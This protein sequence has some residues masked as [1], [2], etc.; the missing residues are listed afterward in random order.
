MM[1]IRQAGL[2]LLALLV[3]SGWTGTLRADDRHAGY[4][5]PKPGWKDSASYRSL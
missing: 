1:A 5:Y 3:L 2:M 4:Y